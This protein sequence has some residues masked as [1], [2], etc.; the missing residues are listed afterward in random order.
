MNRL[1]E[2]GVAGRRFVGQDAPGQD[3]KAVCLSL[4]VNT[5]QMGRVPASGELERG[6]LWVVAVTEKG[7]HGSIPGA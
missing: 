4:T 2:K 1:L 3:H 6:G 5:G 7:Q